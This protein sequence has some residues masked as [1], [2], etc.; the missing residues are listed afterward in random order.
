MPPSGGPAQLTSALCNAK[1]NEGI[2]M[3]ISD[4]P[5]ERQDNEFHQRAAHQVIAGR[6]PLAVGAGACVGNSAELVNTTAS[7]LL[8]CPWN[9]GGSTAG[10]SFER[11]LERSHGPSLAAQP[12]AL[13][14]SVSRIGSS[15]ICS[16]WS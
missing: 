1:D 8:F 16:P 12:D 9:S 7:V 6:Q 5:D 11:A 14:S 4:L 13:V 3:K 2:L 15:L 10:A